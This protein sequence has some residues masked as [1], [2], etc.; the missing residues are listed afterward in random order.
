MSFS[1]QVKKEN[2]DNFLLNL[3]TLIQELEDLAFQGNEVAQKIDIV[4]QE[5]SKIS[6]KIK[7]EKSKFLKLR[8]QKDLKSLVSRFEGIVKEINKKKSSLKYVQ[9]EP[10]EDESTPLL[11]QSKQVVKLD[12]QVEFNEVL[13]QEREQDLQGIESSVAQVNEIF[14]DLGTLVHEQQ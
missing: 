7:Q 11:L 1:H 9:E 8:Y 13:I 10:Q 2:D 3:S 12:N 14:R 6:L 4:S 5:I